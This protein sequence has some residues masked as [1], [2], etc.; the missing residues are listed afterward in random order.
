MNHAR[1]S[2]PGAARARAAAAAA[3]AAAALALAGCALAGPARPAATSPAAATSAAAAPSAATATP[4][5]AATGPSGGAAAPAGAQPSASAPAGALTAAVTILGA[6]DGLLPGG[7]PVQFTVTV[8]NHSAQTYGNILPLVSLG[9][10]TCTASALF[11]AGTMQERESTSNAWQAIPYDVEGFGTDFLQADEPGGIQS[12]SPGGMATFEYRVAL[13]LAA[14]AQ[15]TQGTG[16]IDVTLL[17]LPGRQ[18]AGPV[19]AA[20]AKVYVMPG[21]PQA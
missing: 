9:H 5:A 2:S 20:S 14:G 10:C 15:L 12:L 7:P 6:Q 21:A 16:S 19:P 11:P 13:T 18:P 1:I 3:T 8:T 4:A 17:E